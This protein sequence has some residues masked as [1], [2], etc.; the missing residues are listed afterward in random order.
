[1][2]KGFR[3]T[4]IPGNIL[5][6]NK[7]E[8]A[9]ILQISQRFIYAVDIHGTEHQINRKH[10]QYGRKT[11]YAILAYLYGEKCAKCGVIDNLTIDHIKP[12]HHH[13]S[14]GLENLQLLCEKCNNEKDANVIDYRPFSPT[15]FFR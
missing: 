3:H 10:P 6:I 7:T 9:L 5:A 4:L 14:N 11:I 12:L 8:F 2:G 13:G 15:I 1:M